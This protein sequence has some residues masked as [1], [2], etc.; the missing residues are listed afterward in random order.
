[1][2]A[3]ILI[4]IFGSLL[5][6]FNVKAIKK[7][8]SSFHG[9]LHAAEDDIRDFEVE[10][11]NIRREFAETLLELQTEIE[12]LKLD[13]KEKTSEISKVKSKKNLTELKE[14]KETDGEDSLQF[15]ENALKIIDMLKK[16]LSIDV[17]A[18]QLGTGKGEVLLIKELY[19][20]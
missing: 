5:I 4:I 15:S 10:I 17:I 8:K 11:G 13:S 2:T 20:K 1:M 18:R 9:S 16:G 19:L 7:E 3:F 6:Y 12:E 14:T